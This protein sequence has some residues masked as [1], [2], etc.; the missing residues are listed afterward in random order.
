MLGYGP[1]YGE[2][3]CQI[4]QLWQQSMATSDLSQESVALFRAQLTALAREIEA[5]VQPPE[6]LEFLRL[7]RARIEQ[8]ELLL[9]LLEFLPKIKALD[10]PSADL[11]EG[12][13]LTKLLEFSQF[14]NNQLT[15]LQSV[16]HQIFPE[17]AAYVFSQKLYTASNNRTAL[18]ALHAQLR[19]RRGLDPSLQDLRVPGGTMLQLLQSARNVA[20]KRFGLDYSLS[21]YEDAT[22]N[23]DSRTVVMV[24]HDW[25]LNLLHTASTK[26]KDWA[27]VAQF[28]VPVS[29]LDLRKGQTVL[30]ANWSVDLGKAFLDKL[31]F[32]AKF[33]K[34]G[35]KAEEALQAYDN[36]FFTTDL[37]AEKLR[38]YSAVLTW[39]LEFAQTLVAYFTATYPTAFKA[40]SQ[41]QPSR[42]SGYL[43]W[44]WGSVKTAVVGQSLK[45][46]KSETTKALETRN[47]EVA[48]KIAADATGQEVKRDE[49]PE[50]DV[51]LTDDYNANL[52]AVAFLFLP[53]LLQ[54]FF[55]ALDKFVHSTGEKPMQEFAALFAPFFLLLPQN[56]T[57]VPKADLFT[58]GAEEEKKEQPDLLGRL[59]LR[60]WA[61][62]AA[63]EAVEY[64]RDGPGFPSAK[65]E[66]KHFGKVMSQFHSDYVFAEFIREEL[67]G[68]SLEAPEPEQL[69]VLILDALARRA[70]VADKPDLLHEFD[71]VR[72][73]FTDF[74][75]WATAA[76]SA[77]YFQT[78]PCELLRVRGLD[79]SFVPELAADSRGVRI[80]MPLD[81]SLR[82]PDDYFR[83]AQGVLNPY[84]LSVLKRS[85]AFSELWRSLVDQYARQAPV[86]EAFMKLCVGETVR[87]LSFD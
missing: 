51:I 10:V 34:P 81:D 32:D 47:V 50:W 16:P 75:S 73:A 20:Q 69:E 45:P 85:R 42:V 66:L 68:R 61:G 53:H 31:V 8:L 6:M 14:A 83:F 71:L 56:D 13:S 59:E 9:Q 49:A 64:V 76:P 46:D 58:G 57:T 15:L 3:L 33:L 52:S 63:C 11:A 44:A 4:D 54:P 39:L 37:S 27:E 87:D 43:S 67:R 62:K 77:Q 55:E 79:L 41:K 40:H 84:L 21:S 74:S 86:R 36:P 23:S 38:F 65:S 22:A 19:G 5:T 28:A 12:W 82:D 17:N 35:V 25:D 72:Q 60:H 26:R 80:L 24:V 70:E 1:S 2:L 78:R 18:A 29:S 7:P 48:K 30:N